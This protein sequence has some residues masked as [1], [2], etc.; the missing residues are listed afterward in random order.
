MRLNSY[1]IP[2]PLIRVNGIPSFTATLTLISF[3]TALLGQIGKITNILG[4]IDLTQANYLF[5]ICL[6][7]YL[8]RRI[9]GDGKTVQIAPDEKKPS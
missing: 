9:Q 7:A 1:G 3:L 8:G 2:V 6:A 4:P 5:G